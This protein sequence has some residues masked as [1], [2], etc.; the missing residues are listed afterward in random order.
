MIVLSFSLVLLLGAAVVLVMQR[1]NLRFS[2]IWL[3]AFV[4][5]AAAW[6]GLIWAAWQLPLRMRFGM[7]ADIPGLFGGSN[8]LVMDQISWPLGFSLVSIGLAAVL[9]SLIRTPTVTPGNLAGILALTGLGLAS[10]NA[11]AVSVLLISWTALDLY[12]LVL[13]LNNTRDRQISERIVISFSGHLMGT[14]L[15]SLA[16]GLSGL[17]TFDLVELPEQVSLLIVLAAAFR[18]GVIPIQP[19]ILPVLVPKHGIQTVMRLAPAAAAMSVLARAAFIGVPPAW[20]TPMLVVVMAAGLYGGWNW[21][22]SA[23]DTAG[24]PYWI[25]AF[26]ALGV[27][28]V[29][30]K[31]PEAVIAWGV[32]LVSSGGLLFLRAKKGHSLIWLYGLSVLLMIGLPSTPSWA[33]SELIRANWLPWGVIVLVIM[34]LLMGGYLRHAGNQQPD[35]ERHVVGVYTLYIAAL[36][37]GL[38]SLVFAGLLPVILEGPRNWP[39]WPGLIL[40]GGLAVLALARRRGLKT[41]GIAWSDAVQDIPIRIFYSTLWRLYRLSGRGVGLLS[42]IL[43]GQSALLWAIMLLAFL[44]AIFTQLGIGS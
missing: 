16:V 44:I 42:R 1:V 10:V 12:E 33:M 11:A 7:W 34:L 20:S 19:P 26:A 40:I 14:L 24:R 2:L 9:S 27:S 29:I 41:P 5:A 36:S 38:A 8:G 35:T 32:G 3:T 4:A 31:A 21:M 22:K 39:W 23:D 15:V 18:L 17:A 25:I 37:L 28:A 43:E 6:G 13:Q 30:L